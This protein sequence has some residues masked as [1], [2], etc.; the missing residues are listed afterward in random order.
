METCYLPSLHLYNFCATWVRIKVSQ[1]W[2]WR[3]SER[4]YLIGR[5]VVIRCSTTERRYTRAADKIK[6]VTFRSEHEKILDCCN[7][8][9]SRCDLQ[10]PVSNVKLGNTILLLLHLSQRKIKNPTHYHSVN[11]SQSCLSTISAAII[12][13][14]QGGCKLKDQNDWSLYHESCSSAG[15]HDWCISSENVKQYP[16]ACKRNCSW[17]GSAIMYWTIMSL[18]DRWKKE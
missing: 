16:G 2:L 12:P 14:F 1:S 8:K 10:S 4:H 3:D 17:N 5:Y 7:W 13:D 9:L 15:I 18:D 11:H 6:N